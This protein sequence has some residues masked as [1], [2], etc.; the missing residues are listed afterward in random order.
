MASHHSPAD[1]IVFDLV[2]VQYHALK[3]AQAYDSYVADAEDHDDV[4]AFFE[5]CAA[6]DAERARTCHALLGQL[7]GGGGLAPE[8]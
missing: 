5:Q 7:T 2:S 4:K 1:D 6:Q 3:A 8:S